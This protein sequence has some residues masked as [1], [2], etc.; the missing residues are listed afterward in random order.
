MNAAQTQE[1]Q[2]EAEVMAAFH[3]LVAASKALD[4][5]RYMA[6]IDKDKFTGLGA[7][8]KA[9][10]SVGELE[11]VIAAGFP[12]VQSIDALT[13]DKVKVTVINCST[14]ILVNQFEQRIVLKNGELIS[15]AGGGVQVWTKSDEQWKIV[16]IAASDARQRDDAIF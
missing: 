14:A 4:I 1:R 15:Q 10:H 12:A 5:A 13:F 8:G 9:W 2:I 6:Y 11:R 3:G 7:D 16:S